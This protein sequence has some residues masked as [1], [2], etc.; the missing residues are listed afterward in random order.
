MNSKLLIEVAKKVVSRT[1]LAADESTGTIKKRL[2]TIGIESTPEINRQYRQLLFTAKGIEKYVSGVILYD[3]TIRQST[4]SNIPFPK[5]LIKKGIVPGIKVDKGTINL[6]TLGV[7]KFTQGLDKLTDRLQ[8]YKQLGAQFAKWRAVYTIDESSP[9]DTVLE[10][11]AH[12]LAVYAILC[13]EADIV[14]IV[15][16]EVLMDGEHSLEKDKRVTAKVL[17]IVFKKLKEY[18]VYFPGMILKPNMVTSGKN[19]SQQASVEKV[20]E[21]TLKVLKKTVPS[22]V[23]GVAFL[24]GGQSPDLATTHLD[25][26]NKIRN[27]NKSSYPWRLTASYGRALQGEALEAWSGKKQNVQKAQKVFITR[28][29]KVYKASIGML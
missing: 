27:K 6:P 26:I 2:A 24:S 14:P 25:K 17:S 9:S 7:D 15:E 1:I 12:D 16:P 21:I 20:A 11:N 23:L 29:E 4:D 10:K 5:L 22:S 28:A 8:E 18:G 3:E 19:H 13:Q